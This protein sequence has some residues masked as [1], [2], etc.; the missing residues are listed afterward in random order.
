MLRMSTSVSCN[1]M[2]AIM[3]VLASTPSVVIPVSVLM[4][5]LEMIAVKTLMIVQ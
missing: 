2:P 3:E 5:G 4:A 1:Q